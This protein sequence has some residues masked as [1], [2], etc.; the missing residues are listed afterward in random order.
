MKE[1]AATV[2][3][4]TLEDHREAGRVGAAASAIEAAGGVVITACAIRKRIVYVAG[5]SLASIAAAALA[6]NPG[7]R[8]G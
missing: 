7:D 1:F 3:D 6:G 2:W 5:N 4:I 8:V